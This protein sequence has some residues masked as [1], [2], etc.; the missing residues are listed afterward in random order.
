MKTVL[1][2]AVMLVV[3]LIGAPGYPGASLPLYDDFNAKP[4]LIDPNK[5]FGLELAPE[6]GWAST[7][8]IRQIQNGQLRLLYRAYGPT[9]AKK[10][11]RRRELALVVQNS[12]AVTAIQAT[13]QVT[14]V[15]ATG[16]PPTPD[17]PTPD[18][19]VAWATLTGRF[20]ASGGTD[21]AAIIRLARRSDA[22]DPPN[23][24]RVIAGVAHCDDKPCTKASE[25]FPAKDLGTVKLRQKATLRVQWDQGSHRFIFQRDT[26]KAVE[27]P[28][29]G[30]LMDTE[31]PGI[32]GK[33]L[34]ATLFVPE[35]PTPPRRMAF[36]D[37][38]FD[39]VRV[40]Q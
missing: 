23:V 38:R 20:F 17:L 8:A 5:W 4:R 1:P 19:T 26:A 30:T 40:M 9:G 16:C 12:V 36:I 13:V 11:F 28:Y 22:T 7:E 32:S 35:C 31:K 10:E 21:V 29:Q 33:A 6:P 15:A 34:S 25:P 3:V 27:M 37:A 2:Y 18:L 24:L 14:A 39:D